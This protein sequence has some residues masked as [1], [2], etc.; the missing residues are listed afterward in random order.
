MVMWMGRILLGLVAL[1]WTRVFVKL[2][3]SWRESRWKLEPDESVEMPGVSISVV[4]PARNEEHNIGECLHSVRAQNHSKL[5][6]VVIDDGSTDSTADILEEHVRVDD[7]VL[8]LSGDGVLAEGWF[9]N[10]IAPEIAV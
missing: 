9:G 7:R 5:Q 8:P 1:G 6:I 3:V 4:I 2:V 10:P